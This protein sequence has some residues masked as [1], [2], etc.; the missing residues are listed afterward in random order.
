MCGGIR[1]QYPDVMTRRLAVVVAVAAATLLMAGC[2]GGE[3]GPTAAERLAVAQDTLESTAA[4]TLDLSS[5][6]VPSTVSGVHAATGTAV[7]DGDVVSFEGNIQGKIAG[8]AAA[9]DILAIGADAYV[10]L[11]TPT[12]EPVDLDMLGVPNPTALFAPETGIASLMAATT[13]LALGE[14]VRE[15]S[16]VLTEI[17]GTLA[18]EKVRGLLLLGVADST[19]AVTYAL[20]DDDELR[21]ATLRGNFW[22]DVESSYTIVLTDYGKVIDISAPTS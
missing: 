15:G 16:E 14:Q 10:K 3:E 6:D 13:D 19:F 9:V 18:G 1:G 12:Y 5:A 2:T 20:T 11:F 22:P 4:V 8:A 21:T 17:T 7:R